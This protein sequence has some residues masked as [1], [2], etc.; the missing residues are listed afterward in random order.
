MELIILVPAL[1][2]NERQADMVRVQSLVRDRMRRKVSCSEFQIHSCVVYDHVAQELLH[3]V[4]DL[5]FSVKLFGCQLYSDAP[6]TTGIRRPVEHAL[7]ALGA[8]FP[9]HRDLYLLRVIQDTL[10]DD[11]GALAS[12][13]GGLGTR[14]GPFVAGDLHE[15]AQIDHFLVDLGIPTRTSYRF[16]QGAFMFARLDVWL[17]HYPRLPAPITH[18]CDD[19][20]M[21]QMVV[22]AGGELVPIPGCW[23]HCHDAPAEEFRKRYDQQSEQLGLGPRMEAKRSADEICCQTR[24]ISP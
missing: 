23:C 1:V 16:V 11:V 18:Y 17:E 5:D 14:T 4:L 15:C 9:R 21:S 12:I 24:S 2:A 10:I 19:S 3:T 8:L 7:R 20:V 22:H 13:L 6:N